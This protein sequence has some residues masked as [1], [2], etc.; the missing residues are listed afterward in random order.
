MS[1]YEKQFAKNVVLTSLI[2]ANTGI[3]PNFMPN[4]DVSSGGFISDVTAGE[5][6]ADSIVTMLKNK[7]ICGPF[8]IPPFFRYRIN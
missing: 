7:H 4:I 2:G 5:Q 1:K 6:L 3:N 8:S